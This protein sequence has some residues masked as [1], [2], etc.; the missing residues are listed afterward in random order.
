MHK[1][2]EDKASKE[3][4]NGVVYELVCKECDKVYI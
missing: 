3:E 1:R 2:P 4:S